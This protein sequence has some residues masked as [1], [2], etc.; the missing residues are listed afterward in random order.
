[1]GPPYN[2]GYV[3]TLTSIHFLVT[4][5]EMEAMALAGMFNRSWLPWRPSAIINQEKSLHVVDDS[6]Q[7]N[8]NDP[9]FDRAYKVCP[10]LN[11]VKENFKEIIKEPVAKLKGFMTH[12]DLITSEIQKAGY[13][14]WRN[15]RGTINR[16][17]A[18][19]DGIEICSI[20]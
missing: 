20:N 9:N 3:F 14:C 5:L 7:P 19:V 12:N 8:S 10:L 2:F 13:L 17:V 6:R 4:A 18:E 15:G 11:I 1:M 16:R